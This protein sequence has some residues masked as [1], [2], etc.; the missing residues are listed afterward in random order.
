LVSPRCDKRRVIGSKSNH[1]IGLIEFGTFG[2]DVM[3]ARTDAQDRAFAL[4]QAR[5]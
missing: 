1:I 2:L 5:A 3:R 4:T